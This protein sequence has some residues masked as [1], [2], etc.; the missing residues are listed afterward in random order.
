ML[1]ACRHKG[2]E[3]HGNRSNQVLRLSDM[4]IDLFAD[5]KEWCF[6]K[7]YHWNCYPSD[8]QNYG[9]TAGYSTGPKEADSCTKATMPL[10]P[11]HGMGARQ[12]ALRSYRTGVEGRPAFR[13]RHGP[14]QSTESGSVR[15]ISNFCKEIP[16]LKHF[17]SALCTW[18]GANG[19]HIEEEEGHPG[20]VGNQRHFATHHGQKELLLPDVELEGREP[21]SKFYMNPNVVVGVPVTWWAQ[22]HMPITDAFNRFIASECLSSGSQLLLVS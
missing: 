18:A 2:T 3:A 14:S 16:S 4:L 7:A 11:R 22:V 6:T 5:I 15:N 9:M 20:L 12:K 13:L 19:Q 1:D 17:A 8:I 10:G 21:I